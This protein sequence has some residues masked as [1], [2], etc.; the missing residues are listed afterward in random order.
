MWRDASPIM[1]SVAHNI[2]DKP[3]TVPVS[4]VRLRSLFGGHP[5]SIHVQ[6][7]E[8]SLT[9]V[10]SA[11]IGEKIARTATRLPGVSRDSKVVDAFAGIGGNA[12]RFAY[13]FNTVHA[14]EVDPQLRGMLRSNIEAFDMLNKVF[15][16]DGYYQDLPVAQTTPTILFLDPNWSDDMG[17]NYRDDHRVR[18]SVPAPGDMMTPIEDVIANARARYVIVKLPVN[19]DLAHMERIIGS[20]CHIFHMVVENPPNS[21]RVIYG[22]YSNDD[23][24]AARQLLRLAGLVTIPQCANLTRNTR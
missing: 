23:A 6:Y 21:M 19:Y 14:T 18:I 24:V 15:V 7:T 11:T 16:H 2:S 22:A 12:I 8:E 5:A 9:R 20:R 13:Y 4:P 3:E 10:T 1:E 17:N